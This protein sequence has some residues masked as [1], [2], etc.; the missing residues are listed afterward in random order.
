MYVDLSNDVKT[1]MLTYPY[2]LKNSC[3]LTNKIKHSRFFLLIFT[4]IVC[5]ILKNSPYVLRVKYHVADT[6]FSAV[7]VFTT[8][9]QASELVVIKAIGALTS[10]FLRWKLHYFNYREWGVSITSVYCVWTRMMITLMAVT[11]VNQ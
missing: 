1:I 8:S 5:W 4:S 7:V 9:L 2:I 10:S 3:C 6:S 11:I